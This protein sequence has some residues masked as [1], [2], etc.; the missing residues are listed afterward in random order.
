MFS[1][2]DA[3]CGMKLKIH[4]RQPFCGVGS[5]TLLLHKP[6]HKQTTEKYP[7]AKVF[8]RRMLDTKKQ[9]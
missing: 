5:D 7:D 8:P 1:G 6:I 3:P 2:G 4:Y 9:I